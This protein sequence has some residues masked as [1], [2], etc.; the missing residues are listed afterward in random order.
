M[1]VYSWVEVIC[2][3]AT[4]VSPSRMIGVRACRSMPSSSSSGVVAGRSC[5]NFLTSASA[6]ETSGASQP[7]RRQRAN[8]L[9]HVQALELLEPDFH[10]SAARG[11]G[12]RPRHHRG[13][14]LQALTRMR[15]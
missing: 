8:G 5:S 1:A 4:S 15:C 6:A 11:S 3:M 14:G 7:G 13:S 10:G 9:E 2:P 12:P